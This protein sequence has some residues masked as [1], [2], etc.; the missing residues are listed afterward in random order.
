MNSEQYVYLCC[1][2]N[3]PWAED[4]VSALENFVSSSSEA[5]KVVTN[6]DPMGGVKDLLS[7][8]TRLIRRAQR[9]FF[10]VSTVGHANQP[11]DVSDVYIEMGIAIALNT[12]MFFL[13]RHDTPDHALPT[14]F[15][16]LS[17]HLQYS[18]PHSLGKTLRLIQEHSKRTAHSDICEFSGLNCPSVASSPKKLSWSQRI[19]CHICDSDT[20]DRSDYRYALEEAISRLAQTGFIYLNDAAARS[21]EYSFC[22]IC[23]LVRSTHFGIYRVTHTRTPETYLAIGLSIGIDAL[24]GLDRP[25]CIV[26]ERQEEVPALL[27]SSEV[28]LAKNLSELEKKL[29][30][31]LPSL[32]ATLVGSLRKPVPLA[33][34][35]AVISTPLSSGLAAKGHSSPMGLVDCLL[36]MNTQVPDF[37]ISESDIRLELL[38]FDAALASSRDQLVSLKLESSTEQESKIYEIQL[39]LLVD[40]LFVGEVIMQIRKKKRNADYVIFEVGCSLEKKLGT[41]LSSRNPNVASQVYYFTHVV[42]RIMLNLLG[43]SMEDFSSV[44]PPLPPL[45]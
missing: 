22:A 29:Y 12:P 10:E 14:G 41:A 34:V 15:L 18:G 43:E 17:Q 38:R 30:T 2:T 1:N 27:S 3:L 45:P 19:T 32:K 7:A 23:K 24:F 40:V 36:R 44:L 13:K 4:V 9:C 37:P 6:K 16:G 33:K 25:R 28:V 26:A 35:T 31:F 21:R 39:L 5:S 11:V 42:L 8:K 20:P